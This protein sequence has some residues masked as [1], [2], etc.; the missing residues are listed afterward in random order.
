MHKI[1]SALKG[2]L[3]LYHKFLRKRLKYILLP[4]I[5]QIKINL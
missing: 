4:K 5:Q 3:F 2:A 1:K